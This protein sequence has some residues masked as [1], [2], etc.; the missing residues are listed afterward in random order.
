[1]RYV[2]LS[3]KERIYGNI[4]KSSLISCSIF[5]SHVAPFEFV[6][7]WKMQSICNVLQLE[8]SI[9]IDSRRTHNSCLTFCIISQMAL[10]LLLHR[11]IPYFFP[12]FVYI[13]HF[14]KCSLKTYYYIEDSCFFSSLSYAHPIMCFSVFRVDTHKLFIIDTSPYIVIALKMPSFLIFSVS[15]II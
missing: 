2:I 5:S 6:G 12:N 7:I 11:R 1:M 3:P 10:V 8:L 13:V 15:L 9:F 4:L 14:E